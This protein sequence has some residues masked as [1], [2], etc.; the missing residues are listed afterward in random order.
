MR[1]AVVGGGIAGLTAAYRLSRAGATVTLIEQTDRVGGKLRAGTIAGV[2][3]DVGAEA[4]VTRVP[5]ARV[6]A[7]ELGLA[8]EL[9]HPTAAR[10]TVRAGERTVGLPARTFLGLPTEP[11][12]VREVLSPQGFQ[13]VRAEVG[14]PPVELGGGD[15]PLGT[16]LRERFG[17]ELTDRLVD[18]LLGGVYAGRVD[19]L[20]LRATMPALA[21]ALDSGAGSLTS[22]AA[23]LLGPPK[24]KP[25]PVFSTV[26][27]GLFTLAE[28][29]ESTV[30][31]RLGTPVRELRRREHGWRLVLGAAASAHA[32]ADPVLDV[33]AVVL[34]V[35]PPAARRLLADEVPAASRAYGTI[36][37]ASVAVVT[38]ALPAGTPLPA[39]SGLLIGAEERRADGKPFTAKAFTYSSTK[40]AHLSGGPVLLRGSV[41]RF[42]DPGTLQVD[43]AELITRVRADLAELAGVTAAPLDALVTRWG[44]GLPQYGVGHVDT[45]DAIERAVVDVPGLEVAGAALHGVGIPACIA[46]GES[47]A[48]KVRAYFDNIGRV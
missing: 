15:R 10:P 11:D 5:S 47:A 19:S 23:S 27:S 1:V 16:L 34:A 13:R 7:E 36:E 45:V 24:D 28:Q 32:P 48:A 26:H 18:P 41:G 37:M 29:L 20:G 35:P 43:D 3:A 9:T 39:A 2:R 31:V 8:A 46:T 17:D 21:A 44:G 25:D 12:S 33:D 6:L 40:W 14:L 4:F 38:L 22:A 30:D 42:G